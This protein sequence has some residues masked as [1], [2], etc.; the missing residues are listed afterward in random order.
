VQETRT[1]IEGT[2]EYI[3]TSKTPLYI[4]SQYG[5]NATIEIAGD[6][7]GVVEDSLVVDKFNYVNPFVSGDLTPAYYVSSIIDAKPNLGTPQ[8]QHTFQFYFTNYQGDVVI[9][10]SLDEQGGTP[11]QNTWANIVTVDPAVDKYVNVTGKWN[12]FRIKH[13]PTRGATTA[14]FVIRQTILG[15]YEVGIDFGGRGYHVGDTIS[16][17]GTA[18][19]GS[20][21]TN[22]LLITVSSIGTG[23]EIIAI[24][25][26]GLSYNG[27]KSF[28]LSGDTLAVG[29]LDKV[30]YR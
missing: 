29:T 26:S 17:N 13:L 22:D 10:G 11:R 2:D 14:I 15:E 20:T 21:P 28:V 30:L 8:S 1:A 23:G 9:Q 3:V 25:W 18:L 4:D 12:W 27:V 5:L 24:T 19:G 6:A 7:E 16:M